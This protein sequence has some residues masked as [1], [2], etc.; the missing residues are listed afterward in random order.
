MAHLTRALGA[1]WIRGD[2]ARTRVLAFP[3]HRQG[4]PRPNRDRVV[5]RRGSSRTRMWRCARARCRLREGERQQDRAEHHPLRA[6][7]GK[8]IIAALT[9]GVV[10]EYDG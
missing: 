6:R 8:K 7:N 3:P 10:P 4:K 9:S 2:R 5:S 1:P